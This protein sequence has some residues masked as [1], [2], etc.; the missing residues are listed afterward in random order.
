VGSRQHV[1]ERRLVLVVS[2]V[3]FV[4]TLFYSVIAP[5][6][7][8]LAHQ[9]HLSKLSAG[10]MTASYAAGMLAGSVPGGVLA[11]RAGPKVTLIAG[12]AMLI[13]S[14]IAFALLHD[15][16]GLDAAR[17]VE[18]V[19]GACTWA[20]GIA[21][22]VGEAAPGRRGALMGRT[23]S[24]A[25]VG[26]LCGPVIGALATAVGRLAAFSVIVAAA[27]ALLG[28]TARLPMLR[29]RSHQGV[30]HLIAAL[31]GRRIVVGVWLVA[32]PALASGA[33]TVLAPLRL[34]QFGAGAAAIAGTFLVASAIEALVAPATGRLSDRRGHFAPLRLGLALTAA[35]LVCFDLPGA[36]FALAALVVAIIAALGVFWAPAMAMLSEAAEQH[37]LDQGLA[38]ALMNLAWAAGLILGSGAG[39]AIAKSTGDLAPMA[40]SAAL[41]LATLAAISRPSV[42]L[43]PP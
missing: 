18:G 10:V 35:L 17:L 39:G 29:A 25:V 2:A 23:I 26:A 6:L 14:T 19:G 1:S 20:G 16:A 40:I 3:V 12:L 28:E 24:A 8:T 37:G 36:A 32:L 5:L 31:R 30:G 41:C 7:P 22:M 4:D 42:S 27:L 43:E 13:G 38:A 34:H 33:I 11:A 9:L 21:W 15:V